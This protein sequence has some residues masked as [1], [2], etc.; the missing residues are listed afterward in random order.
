MKKNIC[1][2]TIYVHQSTQIF[3]SNRLMYKVIGFIALVKHFLSK[4]KFYC[5]WDVGSSMIGSKKIV[6]PISCTYSRFLNNILRVNGVS[7]ISVIILELFFNISLCYCWPLF[8]LC[9]L[10]PKFFCWKYYLSF[11]FF[12]NRKHLDKIFRINFKKCK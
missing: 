11:N 10:C 5:L 12:I 2:F 3:K 6:I 4:T 7:V 1:D 8:L 9:I